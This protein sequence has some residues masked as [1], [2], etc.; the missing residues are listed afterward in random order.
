MPFLAFIILVFGLMS[1]VASNIA[2][3]AIM[4][5]AGFLCFCLMC[6]QMNAC[7]SEASSGGEHL[8]TGS[9]FLRG[10]VVIIALT[11]IPFPIW[12]ALSPEGFNIIQDAAGMKVAVA[13]LNVFSKGS[14][15]MYLAR[16]RTDHQT[17]QK[18]LVAVGYVG[19]NGE[20]LDRNDGKMDEM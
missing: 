13:F 8:L 3:K 17:R 2:L 9:S 14:F 15:M 4:Y 7:V 19:D 20:I 10:L 5:C 18:T 12:Y 6:G 16:I 11:W 1:T